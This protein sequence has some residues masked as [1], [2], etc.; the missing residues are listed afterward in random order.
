MEKKS[1]ESDPNRLKKDEITSITDPT[2]RALSNTGRMM[3]TTERRDDKSFIVGED[4]PTQHRSSSS[5]GIMISSF[6]L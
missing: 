1:T 3:W 5:I 4:T 2:S 6:Y